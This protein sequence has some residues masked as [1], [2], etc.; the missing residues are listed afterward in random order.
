M[1]EA[2][3]IIKG[4]SRSRARPKVGRVRGLEAY[5][6][7]DG[8]PAVVMVLVLAMIVQTMRIRKSKIQ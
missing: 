8:E 2:E 3:E 7:K 4:P 1:S 6:S 5:D